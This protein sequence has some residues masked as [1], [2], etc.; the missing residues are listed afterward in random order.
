MIDF[1]NPDT[2][3]SAEYKVN[4]GIHYGLKAYTKRNYYSGI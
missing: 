4:K 3:R 2:T 1:E